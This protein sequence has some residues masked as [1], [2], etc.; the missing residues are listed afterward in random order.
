ME[1][2]KVQSIDRLDISD[3]AIN[4]LKQ[5]NIETLGELCNKTKQELRQMQLMTDENM[6]YKLG[7]N[8]LDKIDEQLRWIGLYLPI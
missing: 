4:L 1:K 5:N 3:N 8:E 2:Y 6:I 7:Q